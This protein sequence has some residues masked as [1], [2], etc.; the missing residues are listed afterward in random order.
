[1]TMFSTYFFFPNRQYYVSVDNVNF[2]IQYTS[3]SVLQGSVLGLLFFLLF[4]KDLGDSCNSTARLFAD[5]SCVIATEN[6][7]AHVKKLYELKQIAKWIIVNNLTI[8]P[9]KTCRVCSFSFFDLLNLIPLLLIYTL[10]NI[11][12]LLMLL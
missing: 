7:P 11:E 1:M 4:I 8:N 10:T 2:S 12:L 3:Y 9:S 5:Y 6:S